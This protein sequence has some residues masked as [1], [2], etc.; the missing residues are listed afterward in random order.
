M[1]IITATALFFL[2]G[3]KDGQL[4]REIVEYLV[5]GTV[6]PAPRGYRGKN[7]DFNRHHLRSAKCW[8]T[9]FSMRLPAEELFALHAV[10]GL[11]QVTD[12]S[13][14]L[15]APMTH[16]RPLLAGPAHD[17]LKE[18]AQ[19]FQQKLSERGLPPYRIILTSGTR[20]RGS[21]ARLEKVNS[22]AASQTA[23]WYGYTFDIAYN[24]FVHPYFFGKRA[25]GQ[26]L[27]DM[28]DETLRELR[29]QK[30]IWVLGERRQA[31]FHITV[32]CEE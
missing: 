30:K 7:R 6:T 22:N 9:R 31:C 20:S 19:L 29:T 16:S 1:D 28:L 23:H 3:G 2:S 10:A 8:D 24:E 13:L 26:E 14:W 27:K 17:A 4:Q 18:I 15:V 21:Q 32:Q 5:E 11:E 25:E 12:N